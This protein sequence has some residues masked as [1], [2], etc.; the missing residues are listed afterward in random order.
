MIYVF[1][2]SDKNACILESSKIWLTSSSS[3]FYGRAP[4]KKKQEKIPPIIPFLLIWFPL[5]LFR[6]AQALEQR[7]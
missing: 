6:K 1:F 7:A 2:L 5:L 3:P 4:P